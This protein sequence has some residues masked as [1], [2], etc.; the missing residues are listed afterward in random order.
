MLFELQPIAAAVSFFKA[1]L[2]SH[3][4][5]EHV[6]ELVEE[7]AEFLVLGLLAERELVDEGLACLLEL[8]AELGVEV[9]LLT[10]FHYQL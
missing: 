7:D 6:D 1:V 3:A 4:L 5:F 10:L 9:Q 8:L 2:V